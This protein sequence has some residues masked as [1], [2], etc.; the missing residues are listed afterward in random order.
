MVDV[1][2]VLPSKMSIIYCLFRKT[3]Y[4]LDT[5]WLRSVV[6]N[7]TEYIVVVVNQPNQY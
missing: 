7:A 5:L 3:R 1:F 4:G 2:L 6:K